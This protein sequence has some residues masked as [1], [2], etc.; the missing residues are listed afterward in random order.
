VA[1]VS[2]AGPFPPPGADRHG[3]IVLVH[4][5]WVGEWSWLPLMGLLKASG[6]P[7]HAVSLTGHGARSHE[8]GP[9][10]GLADHV[11]DV[12]GLVETFDLVD[13]T[14][15]GHSYGGRVITVA[16]SALA[17]RIAAMVYVDAHAPVSGDPGQPPERVEAARTNGGM[18][19]FGGYDPE[20]GIVGGPAGVAWFLARTMP[21]SFRCFTDPWVV[22][23]PPDLPRTFVYATADRPSRFDGYAAAVRDDPRWR[24]H[25]LAGPHWL[26]MSH[27][28][29]VAA[30]VLDADPAARRATAAE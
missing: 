16:R 17:E 9:D 25:E 13:V 3:A 29:E 12:V 18:L 7:V 14:L 19:P 24:Y 30:I 5:A 6:R 11:A 20:P 2:D 22:E 10:V 26:M 8:S 27:P 23:L 28:A 21:H 15:V 4:G 1:G